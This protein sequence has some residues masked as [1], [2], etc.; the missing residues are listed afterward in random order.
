M[1]TKFFVVSGIYIL[2]LWDI[3][4]TFAF[5]LSEGHHQSGKV[6]RI[7]MVFAFFK[8]DVKLIYKFSRAQVKSNRLY[9]AALLVLYQD[10]STLP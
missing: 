1:C 10:K 6:V 5:M 4:L 9:I 8:L 7:A 2:S 3:Q